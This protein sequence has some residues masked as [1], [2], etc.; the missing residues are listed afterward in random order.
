MV[1]H[2]ELDIALVVTKINTKIENLTKSL[3]EKD[4]EIETLKKASADFQTLKGRCILFNV[5]TIQC[6]YYNV[7]VTITFGQC[8]FTTGY[9]DLLL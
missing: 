7:Y 3:A 9:I 5:Y 6:I 4:K 8:S 2:S 1:L